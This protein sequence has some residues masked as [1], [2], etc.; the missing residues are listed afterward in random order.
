MLIFLFRSK[1]DFHI[2]YIIT[3]FVKIA[4]GVNILPSLLNSYLVV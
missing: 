4:P 1:L 2:H 3:I